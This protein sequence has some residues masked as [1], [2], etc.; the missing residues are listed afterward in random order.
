MGAAGLLA[1][2]GI[3]ALDQLVPSSAAATLPI[4]HVLISV[5]ENR[6]FD[7]YY[8]YA[9]FSGKYGVPAG[10]T[11]PD[12]SGG[13]VTPIPND[14]VIT[15]DPNHDW[16]SIHSEWNNGKMDGFYTTNGS[17]GIT[18]TTAQ[19]LQFYYSLFPN[20]TLCVNYFCSVL[21][22]TFPNR[23]YIAGGTSGGITTNNI[24]AGELNWPIILDLL[25]AAGITWKVYNTTTTCSVSSGLSQFYCDNQFEFF[26]R[27]YQDPRVISYTS[28]NYFSD[29][30]NNNLPQ[31]SFLQ[32]NDLTGEH[33]PYG[34][35]VGENL[36]NQL[37]GAL[38]TSPYWASSAYFLTYDEGGGI[39]DHVPP[40]VFDAYGAGIRVP[41]WVISP[42]AKKGHLEPTQYEHAS[43]LKFVERVFNLPTLASQ[44]H[45]FDTQT[46]GGP[47]NQAADGQP[48]GP[49]AP[50][51]DGRSDIGDM[52]QCFHFPA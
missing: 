41:A 13:T 43:L 28:S 49:P 33:P 27:W 48:V 35:N 18:Y 15:P 42:Y 1:P 34:L 26:Q 9:P 30:K 37:I 23:L 38:K 39:F 3:R 12:G 2:I 24:S 21:S 45:E 8:G 31:V 7:S 5:N 20:S 11:Q 51:R 6:S 47:N 14:S 22:D 50:P 32:T 36:Q 44:N 40:P 17:A 25:E 29:L 46:P 16:T 10:Y 4:K 52:M 19:E